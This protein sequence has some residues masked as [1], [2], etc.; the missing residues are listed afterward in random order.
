MYAL[1]KTFRKLANAAEAGKRKLE[2]LSLHKLQAKSAVAAFVMCSAF[3]APWAQAAVTGLQFSVLKDGNA[4]L[5]PQTGSG[6]DN[7]YTNKIVRTSD[8]FDYQL[9]LRTDGAGAQDVEVVSEWPVNS[10]ALWS[11]VPAA[12]GTGSAVENAGRKLVCKIANLSPNAT[13]NITLTGIVKATARNGAD[14]SAAPVSVT[15]QGASGALN[16]SAGDVDAAKLKVTAAPFYDVVV[17]NSFDGNPRSDGFKF[18]NGPDNKDGF[19]HRH[20]VGLVGRHPNGHGRIGVEQLKLGHP[21]H[22]EIDFKTNHSTPIDWKLDTWHSGNGSDSDPKATG[23]FLT[24][25][26]CG[27]PRNGSPSAEMGGYINMHSLVNDDGA[28]H[29]GTDTVPNGGVCSVSQTGNR[30]KLTLTG[31]DTSFERRPEIGWGSAANPIHP[32]EWWVSNKALVLWTDIAQYPASGVVNHTLSLASIQAT[33]IS[34]Q[35]VAFVPPGG[36]PG[37]TNGGDQQRN[38]QY[39]YNLQTLTD[40]RSSKVYS[41]DGSLPAPYAT[42][43]DPAV[44]GD[45]HVNHMTHDQVVA[46]RIVSSNRGTSM[47]RNAEFCEIIDRTAFDLIDGKFRTNAWSSTGESVTVEYGYNENVAGVEYFASTDTAANPYE[48]G[49][50]SSSSAYATADC[51]NPNIRWSTT[52]APGGRTVY[53]RVKL[54]EMNPGTDVFLFVYG[55]KLRKTWA[56]SIALVN[57]SGPAR[58]KDQPIP[59]GTVL[60]NHSANSFNGVTQ[61]RGDYL[62]VVPARTTSRVNKKIISHADPVNSPLPTGSVVEYQVQ[63]RYSTTFPPHS[64]NF[65][66]TDVLPPGLEYVAGSGFVGASQVEPVIEQNQPAAGYTRLR[67][68]LANIE[69]KLGDDNDAANTATIKFKA[70]IGLT[71]ASGSSLV[72]QV[73]VSG[74]ELDYEEDCTFQTSGSG[75]GACNKAARAELKVQTNAGFRINKATLTAAI[76]PGQQFKYRLGYAALGMDINDPDIPELID[77]LPYV[78]DG[79]ADPGR[80]FIA[81]N[82]PSGFDAGAYKLSAVVL[83]S[84]D[85][86]MQVYYTKAVHNTINN[87]P[88]DASNDLVTGSTKWCSSFSGGN[89]PANI[90]EVTAIRFKPGVSVMPANQSYAI[91]L[92]FDTNAGIAKPGDQFSNAVGAR[93]V[94]PAS[95]LLY[96]NAPSTQPVQITDGGASI[97]GRVY[98]DSNDDGNDAGETGIADNTIVLHACVA[99]SNGAVDTTQINMGTTPPSC[100]GDDQYITRTMDTGVN[101]EYNFTGLLTGIYTLVQ[102]NQPTGYQDGTATAGSQGGTVTPKGTTPSMIAD[103]G[104]V[105]GNNPTHA[106]GYNFGEISPKIE[107]HGDDLGRYNA[108]TGGTT[109]SVLGDNGS[110]TDKANGVDATLTNVTLTQVSSSNAG[111]T[112]NTTT[113]LIEVAT[114]TAVGTHTVEY[115]ICLVSHPTICANA[116]ETVHVVSIKAENDDMGTHAVSA[117][118]IVTPSVLA[119]NGAGTDKANG[120]D[121]DPNTVTIKPGTPSN[122]ALTM[123]AGTGVITVAPNTPAGTY[124]YP[125]QICLVN[126]ANVCDEAVATIVIRDPGTIKAENDDMGTHAVSA[127]PIV[128]PSVLADNG[129]GTDKAN[130]ADADPNTVTIKPGTPSNPAL[131]MDAGT[132]VITVAPNTPAGTY[133]YP[134]QICLVNE[135]NVCDEAVATIVIRD[136]GTIKAENDDMGTHAVSTNPIV[137]PSVLADNGAGTDKANGADA[138]PNT[139]TIKPGTPSNPALTMDAGTGVITVAPNTPA[140]TY[141]YPYQI[142]LVNEANVCDEAV[143]TIVIRDPGTIDAVDDDYTGTPIESVSGGSTSSVITNDLADGQPAVIGTN[144]T[145]TPGSV[146]TPPADGGL[147][148]NPDGTITVAS[149]TTPGTYKYTYTICL[150]NVP[151]ICDTATATVVVTPPAPPASADL[152]LTKAVDNATA[153]VGEDVIFTVTVT[154]NGPSTATGVSVNEQLPSGYTLVSASATVGSY[155]APTWT[156]GDLANGATATLTLKATVNATGDYTNT[157][158]VTATTPD[159]TPGNNEDSAT[160]TPPAPPA[161]ADLALTKAVDNATAAVGEDVIFTVTVTNNGPSTATGV[162][163]NEQLPS[164]YT[165]V[166]ASATVGSYSAPTWTIGDLAN[167][168]TATLTLKATVNATGDY[169][170]TATVTATTPDPTPGNNEDSATVTPPAAI[171]PQL[172]VEKRGSVSE[173]EVGDVVLYTIRIRNA[174]QT[175]AALQPVLVDRLPAGFLLLGESAAVSGAK[176]LSVTGAPGSVLRMQLDAIAPGAEAIVQYR[177]RLSVGAQQGDGIN[178]AHM[179]CP[180]AQAGLTI[181]SNE[182]QWQVKPRGGVFSSEGCVVGQIYVDAN[183][184]S[185]KDREELGIP[186]VRMYFQDGTYMISDVEGKYSYCGLRPVTHVLKVDGRT[187]PRG[188]RLVTSSSRNAG[189]AN[190]LFIDL[191]AGELHR[192][193]FIEGS[194]SNEVLEQVKARRANGEVRSVES[195]VGQPALKFESKPAPQGNPLQQGTDSAKQQIERIRQGDGY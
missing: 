146:V 156:I 34:D 176:L 150:A 126:E 27:S 109:A 180:M 153:A 84:N 14:I 192:A 112:L 36:A 117:N 57:G 186:G 7:S 32:S 108:A 50:I 25:A 195:E 141:T 46:A 6:Y 159:P 162:S 97:A 105:S 181:C 142:C 188:S 124:T 165:L 158:T 45:A 21:V 148:M 33:S 147:T 168:A 103:F 115:Q 170:N 91:E 55:M 77:I 10:N 12:C 129:A 106:T 54:A 59:A 114:G 2:K 136:P 178:R 111:V 16:P 62:L 134:Y 167:G 137:T 42:V 87:D 4:P 120:A 47:L 121:A 70:R 119:D 76:E 189:D 63:P 23:S 139:V 74:G 5:D 58:V 104:L 179:E 20:L 184:N 131:T 48:N 66:V 11:G 145:L 43:K 107:A 19:F 3:A 163:V 67:W 72:N 85:P 17:R 83:P 95:S 90:G 75:Y 172:V 8:L 102:Q 82:P 61:F 151:D 26:G 73:A 194:A 135:A 100:Q 187:L 69:P 101:G 68:T 118:P 22:I 9:T 132:G 160:V 71:V 138:D 37:S 60:R 49:N 64:A 30:V 88:R 18:G 166:S 93:P 65:T 78:G 15:F 144:V 56:A 169:T 157:A 52:P 40:G 31:V 79:V 173:A 152:A 80:N 44:P 122:P 133:T 81:R 155:S 24:G 13:E 110:G 130:G 127:N 191:K 89:C 171:I 128:T 174:N 35:A 182:D 53:V 154:N 29:A 51:K 125:Y 92:T 86:G 1:V 38:N 193:D 96:V 185:L 28:P 149:G 116:T 99:G 39:S 161:S 94:N 190:S 143:A 140:G 183:G 164:G 98:I 41:P 113:G 177:V 175:A 123:D